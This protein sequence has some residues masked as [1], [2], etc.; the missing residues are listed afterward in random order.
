MVDQFLFLVVDAK[1]NHA[2]TAR[3]GVENRRASSLSAS[4]N[5]LPLKH[6]HETL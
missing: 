6:G 4:G 3:F 5:M 2:K 1:S